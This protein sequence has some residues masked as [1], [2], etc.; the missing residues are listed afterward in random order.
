MKHLSYQIEKENAGCKL[1]DLLYK[2]L[3]LSTAIITKLKKTSGIYVNHQNKYLDY[4]VKEGDIITVNL[5]MDEVNE[6]IPESLPLQII[7]E[8]DYYLIINKP[9]NM[10]VHPSRLHQS[11]TLANAVSYYWK[12]QGQNKLFRPVNR[13]DKNTSGLIIIAQS[14]YSH[15]LLA[16]S[17]EK[18]E[19]KRVYYALVEGNPVKPTGEIDVP[20][21][22]IDT[23]IIMRSVISSGQRACTHFKVLKT[24]QDISLMQLQL[25]TGRT[26]Q[27]RVH[28]NYIGHPLVGDSL[29]GG[30]LGLLSRQA[31]HAG[32][33]S[34]FHP[35]LQKN[36]VFHAP[37]PK[38]LRQAILNLKRN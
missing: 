34:F 37:F 9:A 6:I 12:N 26:H 29:Y 2:K 36:M 11:G 1:R 3:H 7:Y 27:I 16:K 10:P 21:G 23:S 17:L 25:E 24:Y 14:Q 31:L 33:L 15:Q 18:H 35:L 28:M 13:L 32:K 22:R 20:I 19:L 8:D 30:H 5:K 38:D 4:R